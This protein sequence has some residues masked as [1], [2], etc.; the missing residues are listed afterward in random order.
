VSRF[1]V[2]KKADFEFTWSSFSSTATTQGVMQTF[3]G[4]SGPRTLMTIKMAE[5]SGRDVRDFSLYPGENEILFPPNMCFEVVDSFDAGNQ[6]IMVQCRQT[7]TVDVILDLNSAGKTGP[8]PSVM[9]REGVAGSRSASA[10]V[11]PAP[12]PGLPAPPLPGLEQRQSLCFGL[13]TESEEEAAARAE[14]ERAEAAARAEKERAEA[15][16]RAEKALKD[17]LALRLYD[18]AEAERIRKAEAARAKFRAGITT[19]T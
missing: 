16:A 11:A 7:E 12:P 9:E 14:K 1:T 4:Q 18:E 2:N 10:K 3:V 8:H 19:S 15:A 5:N 6:L 17:A 13:C